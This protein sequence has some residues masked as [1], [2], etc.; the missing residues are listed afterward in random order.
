[1]KEVLNLWPY[2]YRVH[3]PQK[4]SPYLSVMGRSSN[5]ALRKNGRCFL[6]L[7]VLARNRN[8]DFDRGSPG[9]SS[10]NLASPLRGNP[11]LSP[12]RPSLYG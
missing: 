7:R 11:Y 5:E 8:K 3:L 12:L 2:S 1:M 10:S 4:T 9:P 6:D